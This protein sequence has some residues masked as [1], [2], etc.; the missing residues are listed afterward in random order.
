MSKKRALF[1]DDDEEEDNVGAAPKRLEINESYAKSYE[2]R[3]TRELLS[4]K[5]AYSLF[6][7]GEDLDED[8]E[9]ASS[10]DEFAED[11][12]PDLDNQISQT[13]A[14]IRSKDPKIYR[15][16]FE[17]FK[18]VIPE[19]PKPATKEKKPMLYQDLI[20]E[21]LK[22]GEAV[23]EDSESEEEGDRE[24]KS[25]SYFE[26]Q[27]KLKREFQLAAGE[28]DDEEEDQGFTEEDFLFKY[29]SDRNQWT[30][31]A[32]PVKLMEEDEEEEEERAEEF[33][34]QFLFRHLDPSSSEI[35]S[36]GRKIEGSLRRK[37]NTR[38]AKRDE[39][40]ERKRQ[41]ADS[42]REE[43]KRLKNLKRK[44]I[45][46]ELIE[47]FGQPSK[48][49][50]QVLDK[51][52]MDDLEGDFDPA[53]WD[54]KMNQVF[55][56]E[57]YKEEDEAFA[58]EL[59]QEED[60][61]GVI[62]GEGEEED[63][64]EAIEEYEEE[65]PVRPLTKQELKQMVED[66]LAKEEEEED[67]EPEFKFHY[68]QVEPND[69]GIDETEVLQATNQELNAFVSLKRMAPFAD[70]EWLAS[71]QHRK[72]F[73]D[74]LKQRKQEAAQTTSKKEKERLR[75][76]KNRFEKSQQATLLSSVVE[77][78]T[79]VAKKPATMS[80]ARLKSFVD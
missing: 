48:S 44:M 60:G 74:K 59:E 30:T 17:P 9:E 42:K 16:D 20:R 71:A 22:R 47:A 10:E 25:P 29:L 62:E 32:A 33:E 76:A 63:G 61:G 58:H 56:D 45:E 66:R 11:L 39:A 35:V 7:Q 23:D 57:Y 31:Q 68:R 64:G 75:V 34:Q 19:K 28:D 73:R 52:G 3:K 46:K 1:E 79:V 77:Q 78:Q 8:G 26:Q 53:T 24:G 80:S 65:E 27:E 38:K 15:K 4:N 6:A 41:L 12:T 51:F 37:E 43:L 49:N 5:K 21:K 2:E 14:L 50:V 54:S 70:K 13:I 55:N 40:E 18:N 67:E 69:Y 36:H 72:K